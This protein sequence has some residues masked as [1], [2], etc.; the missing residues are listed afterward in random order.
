MA[1]VRR[2]YERSKLKLSYTGEDIIDRYSKKAEFP[3]CFKPRLK[4]FTTSSCFK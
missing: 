2:R 4:I 1:A 3:V